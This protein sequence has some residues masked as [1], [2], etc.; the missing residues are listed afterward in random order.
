VTR[1]LSQTKH[2]AKANLA[3][4]WPKTSQATAQTALHR[5]THR[6]VPRLHAVNSSAK[7]LRTK[8]LHIRPKSGGGGPTQALLGPG[9]PAHPPTGGRYSDPLR[10]K[11]YPLP[12]KRSQNFPGPC[13]PPT[14]APLPGGRHF[15]PKSG[16]LCVGTQAPPRGGVDLPLKKSLG[17]DMTETETSNRKFLL[18]FISVYS[19]YCGFSKGLR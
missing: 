13:G 2:S 18:R 6:E 3:G 5:S 16:K 8:W 19:G 15:D 1:A 7:G 14:Q 17:I 9:L 4:P 11:I 10:P 12:Y